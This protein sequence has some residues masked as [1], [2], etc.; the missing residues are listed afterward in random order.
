MDA[1]TDRR[2]A[3]VRLP[4]DAASVRRAREHVA[5]FC[6][7]H[8]IGAEVRDVV[9]LLVSELATNAITHA[10]GE[11]TVTVRIEADR[12]TVEVADG[13][14]RQPRPREEALPADP[15][16][17]T[18]LDEHGRGLQLVQALADTWGV[19]TDH[20]GKRVHFSVNPAGVAYDEHLRSPA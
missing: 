15:G 19:E 4:S 20:A 1:T 9:R 16:D 18:A 5:T 7:G 2:S 8:A 12:L 13:S 10:Q 3:S 11:V 17:W 6:D 14:T